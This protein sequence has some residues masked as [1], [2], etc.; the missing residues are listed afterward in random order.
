MVCEAQGCTL[1]LTQ[2]M[3][4]SKVYQQLSEKAGLHDHLSVLNA[5]VAKARLPAPRGD[6]CGRL[7]LLHAGATRSELQGSYGTASSLLLMARG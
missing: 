7:P 4:S 6:S 5:C 3:H 2:A 1:P